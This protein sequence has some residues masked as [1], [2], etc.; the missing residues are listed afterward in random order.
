MLGTVGGSFSKESGYYVALDFG[1]EQQT[2]WL[3][4]DTTTPVS[5]LS[6]NCTQ[7]STGFSNGPSSP[8]FEPA[9][10]KTNVPLTCA[11][12]TCLSMSFVSGTAAVGCGMARS[13]PGDPDACE[14]AQRNGTLS[15]TYVIFGCGSY[16]TG[17]LSGVSRAPDGVFGLG[18]GIQSIVSVAAAQA[19]WADTFAL[20]LEGDPYAKGSYVVLGTSLGPTGAQWTTFIEIADRHASLSVSSRYCT[21]PITPL[22]ILPPSFTPSSPSSSPPSPLYFIHIKGV[23]VAGTLLSIPPRNFRPPTPTGEGG[24]VLDSSTTFTE[25][26]A[27][28]FRALITAVGEGTCKG[29]GGAV[30]D[31][32]T[33]FTELPADV[34]RALITAV[35]ETVGGFTFSSKD[36]AAHSLMCYI[37]TEIATNDPAAFFQRFPTVTLHL[38]GDADF[39]V[40]P[41]T[42]LLASPPDGLACFAI[43]RSPS[44]RTVL[45]ES[46]LRNKYIWIERQKG[47]MAWTDVNCTT[48]EPLVATPPP[49]STPAPPPPP[50]SHAL[51][52]PNPRIHAPCC[53][54]PSPP[55]L[56]L[57]LPPLTLPLPPL[58]HRLPLLPLP[59]RP[60]PPLHLP[61]FL[62]PSSALPSP[63]ISSACLPP[64]RRLPSPPSPLPFSSSPSPP[65]PSPPPPS[66]PPPSPPPPSPPPPSPPPPS[67]PP[68]SPPPPDLFPPPP[69]L[70]RPPFLI[71]APSPPLD[72]TLRPT[73]GSMR[74]PPIA[75]PP[76]D[77]PASSLNPPSPDSPPSSPPETCTAVSASDCDCFFEGNDGS[78]P[79]FPLASA[80]P[81]SPL[82]PNLLC[83]V[84]FG[85]EVVCGGSGAQVDASNQF[86]FVGSSNARTLSLRPFPFHLSSFPVAPSS[87]PSPSAPLLPSP[88]LPPPSH[89]SPKQRVGSTDIPAALGVSSLCRGNGASHL[90][91]MQLSSASMQLNLNAGDPTAAVALAEDRRC[92][93]FSLS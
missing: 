35:V 77:A 31:S 83:R 78:I 16:Q 11:D 8:P 73:H 70:S 29:E 34:F 25:L 44:L 92:A 71:A 85:A 2:F 88:A 61:L 33:T 55:P 18:R 14:Y 45:A 27:D 56:T 38:A 21:P 51:P 32:S 19:V 81:D 40:L 17:S 12:K 76:P 1:S 60:I 9:A 43:G 5:W 10:S 54:P 26:P 87:N 49:T 74:S 48:N 41:Q 90:L 58:P 72:P 65:P 50:P 52:S 89:S 22:S 79:S 23:S 75:P 86:Y 63:R 4:I 68:P 7:C 6:C 69:G 66:P 67:P 53:S 59:L 3:Q 46:W 93:L 62:P 80:L 64:A 24:A 82:S 30:Q 37:N 47:V 36:S 57:P 42:Y 15:K 39:L 28:V 20:C 84:G 13:L 91:L